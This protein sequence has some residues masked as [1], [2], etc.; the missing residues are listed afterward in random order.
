M[1]VNHEKSVQRGSNPHSVVKLV[2][3][4]L[5][6]VLS[7]VM[8]LLSFPPYGIWPFMWVAFIPYIFAQYRL[9]PS[10]WSS[11]AVALSLLFWLGPFLARLFGTEIGYF[12]TFLGVWIA[13]LNLFI[14]KE[15]SF[16]ELT[17][18]KWFV[19]G[20]AAGHAESDRDKA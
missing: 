5:L 20:G 8:M 18:H 1:S 9:M 3:G 19:L 10:K 2:C 11:L 4:I 16:H 12:F 6:S 7:G 14:S 17:Q 13:I 15:R